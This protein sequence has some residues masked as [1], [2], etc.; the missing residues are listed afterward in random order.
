MALETKRTSSYTN[1]AIKNVR[2][3][4]DKNSN[5][6]SKLYEKHLASPQSNRRRLK[7]EGSSRS[8]LIKRHECTDARERRRSIQDSMFSSVDKVMGD[9]DGDSYLKKLLRSKKDI[10]QVSKKI[11]RKNKRRSKQ[12][13]NLRSF[14]EDISSSFTE[15]T[16]PLDNS[17]DNSVSSDSDLMDDRPIFTFQRGPH[18]MVPLYDEGDEKTVSPRSGSSVRFSKLAELTYLEEDVSEF[19]DDLFYTG[20]EL[21]D[22]RHE[23]FLELCEIEEFEIEEFEIEEF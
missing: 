10:D 1:L 4:L 11:K 17:L 22:F 2:D 16:E 6:L 15:A 18:E 12:A 20:E 19:W 13:N 8:Y 3:S 7:K 5:K 21:A 14:S 23:A 9:G